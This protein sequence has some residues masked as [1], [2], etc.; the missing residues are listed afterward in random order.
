MKI[1]IRPDGIWYHGSDRVFAELRAGSTVTQWRALAEAFSHRPSALW[2]DDDG[3]IRH[4][5]TAKGYL[6]IID[7]PVEAGRDVYP[8]PRTTMDQN[9]EFLTARPLRVRLLCEPAGAPSPGPA[10]GALL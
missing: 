10:G 1:E 3:V 5:G 8:H 9:A 6:Y 7:E 4:N 2:Y